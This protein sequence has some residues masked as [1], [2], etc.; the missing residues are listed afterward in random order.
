MGPLWYFLGLF[1]RWPGHVTEAG[2]ATTVGVGADVDVHPA[3]LWPK[4]SFDLLG[5]LVAEPVLDVHGVER[6][7]DP[8]L[9]TLMTIRIVIY[10]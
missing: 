4:P 6:F 2:Q 10:G 3:V 5:S 7:A 8:R 9:L 1:C